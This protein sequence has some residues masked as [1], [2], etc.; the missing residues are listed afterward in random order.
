MET[1]K[2]AKGGRQNAR[3]RMGLV[4]AACLAGLIALALP[5]VRDWDDIRQ[6]FNDFP[7][8]Y[9]SPRLLGTGHLYDQTA[10]LAEQGRLLGRTSANIQFIRLPYFA[11]MLAPLS[12]LPYLA[13]YALW[14][15]LS[16]AALA[17]FAWLWPAN[18][19]LAHIIICWFLPVAAN[20]AN[21]QDVAYILLWVA[22]AAAL[23]RRGRNFSAGLML[24]LC[25]AKF[26]LFLFLPV[27]IVAKR[28]WR[29]GAGLVAGGAFLL[30][31][32]FLAAGW[33]WP[34]AWLESIRSPLPNPNLAKT[35]LL[36]LV[37]EAVHGPGLWVVAGA[38]VLLTGAIVYGLAQ[39]SSFTLGLG[40][41]LAGGLIVAFHVYVQDYLLALPLIL[42]L[43]SGL[44]DRR[45]AGRGER[46]FGL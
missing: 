22:I 44:V 11:V 29:L 8:F 6:G 13:A 35:S 20:L 5:F 14:Q 39:R 3:L 40:A 36:G 32:S 30:A 34:A 24:A 17:G 41:A 9:L 38:L 27:L 33:G 31:V 46:D 18:R 19:P 28:M 21:G 2:A 26:H 37:A 1:V 25:A 15:T 45:N 23:V 42:T 7:A 4:I 10:F 43:A 16:I 12:H